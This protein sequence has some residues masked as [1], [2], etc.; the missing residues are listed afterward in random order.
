LEY[1][2]VHA[3]DT[4]LTPVDLGA[5]SSRETFMVG[6]ACIDAARKLAD[7]V[8]AA[9]AEAW[10]VPASRVALAGGWAFDSAD[11]A[12]KMP[13]AEAFNLAE[14]RFGTLGAVGWYNTPKDIHGEYRGGTIGASPAYSFT[15]HVAEV[16]VDVET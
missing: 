9:V 7:Q 5:Y 13:I 11:T 8:K 2:R 16:S 4:D 1:V 3:A 12:R 14:A 6:N 10:E 15:A